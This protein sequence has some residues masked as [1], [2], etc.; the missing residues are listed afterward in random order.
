MSLDDLVNTTVANVSRF[1]IDP[2]DWKCR[3][4]EL[5]MASA[6]LFTATV[7][8][9]EA[10]FLPAPEHWTDGAR[11]KPRPQTPAATSHP[12]ALTLIVVTLTLTSAATTTHHTQVR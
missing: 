5:V 1:V 8:P 10:A 12:P 9:I 3:R 4:W 11:P 7:T 6:L 2:R